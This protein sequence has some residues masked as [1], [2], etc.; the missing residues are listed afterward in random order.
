MP[1]NPLNCE[2]VADLQLESLTVSPI[3]DR[4][5]ILKLRRPSVFGPARLS[6]DKSLVRHAANN[7]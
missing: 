1:S 6:R 5:V 3:Q 4:E 7:R 2:S